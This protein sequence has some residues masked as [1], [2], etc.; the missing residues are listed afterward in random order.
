LGVV[1]IAYLGPKGTF[2]E[3]ALLKMAAAGLLLAEEPDGVRRLPMDSTLA[4]LDAVRD[5]A[6][7]FAYVPI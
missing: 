3:A 4:A 1:C 2:T 6:A 7:E 5:G